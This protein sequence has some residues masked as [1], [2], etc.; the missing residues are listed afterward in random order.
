LF[1][2]F[3]QPIAGSNVLRSHSSKFEEHVVRGRRVESQRAKAV[4][5]FTLFAQNPVASSNAL[6][7]QLKKLGYISRHRQRPY[8]SGPIADIGLSP[9]H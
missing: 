5:E 6:I 8:Q 2:L 4:D 1:Q 7:R 3:S 9:T